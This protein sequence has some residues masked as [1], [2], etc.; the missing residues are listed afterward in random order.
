MLTLLDNEPD[1]MYKFEFVDLINSLPVMI[2]GIFLCYMDEHWGKFPTFEKTL[3]LLKKE[4]LYQYNYKFKELSEKQ[5][6]KFVCAIQQLYDVMKGE[7]KD[8][9]F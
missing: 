8:E 9:E 1:G 3:S 7:M 6:D 5:Q 4:L 2:R